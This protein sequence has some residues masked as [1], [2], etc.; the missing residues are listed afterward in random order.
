MKWWM[1]FSV[2]VCL[3]ILSTA[4]VMAT[5]DGF[6]SSDCSDGEL[7]FIFFKQSSVIIKAA[8]KTILIDPARSINKEVLEKVKR[9]GLDLL[10]YTHAHYDHYDYSAAMDL[11]AATGA[12]IVAAP[13]VAGELKRE[14]PKEKMTRSSHQDRHTINGIDVTV[15]KGKHI[16]PIYLYYLKIDGLRIFH[17]GDSSYIALADY[18]SDV[19]FL[20][21]GDP[22][23][24]CSPEK[25]Y[26][27]AA[28]VN[29]KVAVAIHGSSHQNEAFMAKV[30]GGL[31]NTRVI[32][33][34]RLEPVTL[35]LGR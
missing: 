19:A 35:A 20:P 31:P 29:P 22:S 6:F 14:I 32:V 15:I 9:Q 28:D 5:D 11:F 13:E 23:P 26:K 25:A 16:G 1:A 2:A 18:P 30:Q 3:C 21:T 7:K 17:G 33:P 12:H 8:G 4:S 10:M 34:D 24:T 27:M